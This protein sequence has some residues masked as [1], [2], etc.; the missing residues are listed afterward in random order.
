MPEDMACLP[1]NNR[2]VEIK[3]SK[4]DLTGQHFGRLTVTKF[5]R[6]NNRLF[7]VCRCECGAERAYE[8]S[9]LKG[10]HTKSCGCSR[11]THGATK[12]PE[13]GIWMGILQRCLNRNNARYKNYG[14]RGIA[15]CGRY[16][17]GENGKSG[18]EVF[19]SETIEDIGCRPA[20]YVIDRIDNEGNYV[21][22]NLRW[23]PPHESSMNRR[24]DRGSTSIHKGVFWND[25]Y[26]A[27]QAGIKFKNWRISLGRF[28][29]EQLAAAHYNM[30]ARCLFSC[31]VFNDL[32]DE[33][34][35]VQ[36]S[37]R[38][39]DRIN[40]ALFGERYDWLLAMRAQ[41]AVIRM[42][43]TKTRNS[44]FCPARTRRLTQPG[45][46]SKTKM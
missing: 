9:K 29:C 19:L 17:F 45:S 43:S 15:V 32:R 23:L 26:G 1:G 28:D 20:G 10:G 16:R 4:H 42:C 33:P 46:N 34:P 27:W 41:N 2:P 38:V 37:D 14:G 40:R 18:F 30:A 5:S 8:Q 21:R 39:L 31:P 25:A 35:W 12:T 44:P 7:W 13:Y 11:T 3:S 22:G 6:M 24:G 36:L